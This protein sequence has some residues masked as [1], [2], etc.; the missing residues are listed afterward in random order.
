MEPAACPCL[1]LTCFACGKCVRFSFA[2]PGAP[3]V[4]RLGALGLREGA[5]CT[6]LQNADKMIV[7]IGGARLGLPRELAM[8]LFAEEVAS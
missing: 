8:Q 6:I 2:L 4:E 1:P 5:Q 7:R 3:D